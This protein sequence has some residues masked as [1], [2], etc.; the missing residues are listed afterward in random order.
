MLKAKGENKNNDN[1]KQCCHAVD[2]ELVIQVMHDIPITE[3]ATMQSSE[4]MI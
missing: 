2:K 3:A 1:W 4:S